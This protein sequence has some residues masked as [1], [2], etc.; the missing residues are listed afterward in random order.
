MAQLP[1]IRAAAADHTYNL[2]VC[3][4]RESNR[5]PSGSGDTPA[6]EPHW[7]GL[8]SPRSRWLPEATRVPRLWSLA[9]GFP[10]T[11]LLLPWVA[12][13]PR[14]SPALGP[15]PAS[16]ELPIALPLP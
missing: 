16:D 9:M 1:P 7:Q 8:C 4:D 5:Q 14:E 3:P 10:L 15:F 6:A 13:P 11:R 2:D 12:D